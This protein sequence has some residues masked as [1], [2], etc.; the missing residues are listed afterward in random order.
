[1]Q[2]VVGD[3]AWEH[4]TNRGWV[5]DSFETFQ[6]RRYNL[7]VEAL[8]S[9]RAWWLRRADQVIVPSRY[10]ARWVVNWGLPEKR[11]SVIYNAVVLP[12]VLPIDEQCDTTSSVRSNS[13]QP[14][15]PL[16]APFKIITVGRL[17]PWKQIDKLLEAIVGCEP[18]G[19]VI[20]GEG[21][22][23]PSLQAL[24]QTL[25]VSDRIYFAGARDKPET[26]ALMQACDLFVLNSTYE[27]LPHV[28]L[29]AMSLGLPVVAT[30]VGGTPEIVRDGEN[31]RLVSPGAT[32]VLQD[33][34]L[35][36][37]IAEDE[38]CRLAKG[39]QQTAR[40]WTLQ[41]MEIET[42]TAL[43]EAVLMER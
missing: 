25:G 23:R 39:A 9:L 40:Q 29:E 26:I 4:A 27:G 22:E 38:R 18:A 36:L 14:L 1:V 35:K 7:R 42:E 3:L 12:T 16:S 8:K 24:A 17:V 19:L 33:I 10:L 15:I 21:P 37:A 5:A 20:V 28:I 11:I 2:K 43:S 32:D 6:R 30:S 13:S 34:L 41:H 31:G